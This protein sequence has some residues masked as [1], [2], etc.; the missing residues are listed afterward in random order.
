MP[1]T[2]SMKNSIYPT[3]LRGILRLFLSAVVVFTALSYS[4]PAQYEIYETHGKS[5]PER[6]RKRGIQMLTDIKEAVEKY[7]YDKSFRGIDLDKR[8]EEAKDK[9]KTLDTNSEIFRV[10]ASVLLQFGDS[11]TVFIPP[12][13]TNVV[14]YGF[15]TQMVGDECTVTDVQKGSDA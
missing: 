14:E 7:Y 12:G 13:R 5:S 6:N 10:I 15:T 4:A 11:H 3:T 8:F 9:I 2:V 1:S